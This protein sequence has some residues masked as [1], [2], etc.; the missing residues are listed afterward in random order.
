MVTY[1][2]FWQSLVTKYLKQVTLFYLYLIF[3]VVLPLNQTGPLH[4]RD[5]LF[6]DL[7][8]ENF[9]SREEDKIDCL[10][11]IKYSGYQNQEIC[12]IS[13]TK[14]VL[15]ISKIFHNLLLYN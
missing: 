1:A 9:Y 12:N 7:S 15:I 4:S 14:T 10:K 8:L 11:R 13:E 3:S 2:I 6:F 5:F